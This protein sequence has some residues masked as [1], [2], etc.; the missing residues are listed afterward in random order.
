MDK[1]GLFTA[2]MN[3]CT[4]ADRPVVCQD[5]MDDV[6]CYHRYKI[7]ANGQVL[8][9]LRRMLMLFLLLELQRG[10]QRWH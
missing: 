6:G 10:R 2:Y 1:Y 5:D 3:R 9:H 7:G 4:S 8:R